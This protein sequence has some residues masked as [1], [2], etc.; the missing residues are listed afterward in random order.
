MLGPDAESY[1]VCTLGCRSFLLFTSIKKTGETEVVE[2]KKN[3]L[4]NLKVRLV[5]LN[6]YIFSQ[7]IRLAGG[8]KHTGSV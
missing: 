5:I 6:Y 1:E 7:L 2:H 4:I 3:Y 8:T